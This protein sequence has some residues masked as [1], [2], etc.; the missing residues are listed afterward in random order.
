MGGGRQREEESERRQQ[1]RPS[2]FHG[3]N[4][5]LNRAHLT[6][7]RRPDNGKNNVF[8][9]MWRCH[10]VRKS[11]THTTSLHLKRTV[12]VFASMRKETVRFFLDWGASCVAAGAFDLRH[13][14]SEPRGGEGSGCASSAMV[15]RSEREDLFGKR[16]INPVYASSESAAR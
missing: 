10:A 14:T 3:P 4:A 15:G 9:N 8:T 5:L 6:S 7:S 11:L 16:L 12:A 1:R 13:S 2:R